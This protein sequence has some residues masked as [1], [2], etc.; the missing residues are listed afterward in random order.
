[1]SNRIAA[2]E[3]S[4]RVGEPTRLN[5]LVLRSATIAVTLVFAVVVIA[6]VVMA[7]G[8]LAGYG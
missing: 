8:V 2:T 6:C 3:T 7:L 5:Y 4:V 1:M